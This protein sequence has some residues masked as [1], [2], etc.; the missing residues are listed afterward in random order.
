MTSVKR[1]R[2]FV[3]KKNKSDVC[4]AG[5]ELGIGG[6]RPTNGPIR[7]TRWSDIY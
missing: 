2:H 6:E 5:T 1:S 3:Q 7:D 4:L